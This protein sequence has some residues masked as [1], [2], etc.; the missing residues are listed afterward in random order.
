MPR[1]PS[2][3]RSTKS[4]SDSWYRKILGLVKEAARDK[5]EREQITRLL[6][7]EDMKFALGTLLA[8]IRKHPKPKDD[9]E[10]DRLWLIWGVLNFCVTSRNMTPDFPD[11]LWSQEALSKVAVKTDDLAVQFNDLGKVGL[12]IGYP[13]GEDKHVD[14]GE[15]AE[16]L[17]WLAKNLHSI[18]SN[19]ETL[20]IIR[21]GMFPNLK[22]GQ[23]NR[24]DLRVWRLV[25]GLATIF[26]RRF[27]SPCYRIVATFN[28]AVF[29]DVRDESDVAKIHALMRATGRIPTPLPGFEDIQIPI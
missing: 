11:C 29:K 27:G 12:V 4:L 1:K 10:N 22:P 23:G 21:A 26:F 15:V 18:A 7:R 13:I 16:L 20:Q 9:S 5:K 19:P 24:P 2:R 8:E 25:H 28:N 3:S 6:N 17:H 14:F